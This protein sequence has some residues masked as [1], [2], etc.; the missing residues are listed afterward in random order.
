MNS[1]F[2]KGENPEFEILEGQNP[3]FKILECQNLFK[4]LN[5]G[6]LA[7][8]F[9]LTIAKILNSRFSKGQNH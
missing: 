2:W 8:E 6:F 3:E 5:S 4:I 9:E 7:L 1:R